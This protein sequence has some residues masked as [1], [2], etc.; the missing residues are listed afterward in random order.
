[1][2]HLDDKRLTESARKASKLYNAVAIK[3]KPEK[4]NL[5]VILSEENRPVHVFKKPREVLPEDQ[6]TE[7][8][9]KIIVRDYFP[10]LP[11]LKAQ[12]EYLDALES[13]D[14]EALRRI[15]MKF[16]ADT[17]NGP[18][19]TVRR[20]N[21]EERRFDVDTEMEVIA[22]E[23]GRNEEEDANKPGPSNVVDIEKHTVQSFVDNFVSEDTKSFHD[24]CKVDEEAHRKVHNWIY[25]AEEKHN[26]EFVRKAIPMAEEA[27]IQMIEARKPSDQ[28][29]RPNGLDNWSYKAK[30]TVLFNIEGAAPTAKEFVEQLKANQKVINKKATR[31]DVK[32]VG[33]KEPGSQQSAGKFVVPKVDISGQ[34]VEKSMSHGGFE[35]LPTPDPTPQPEDSPFITWG[36]IDGTPFRLDGGDMT[37]APD[38]A[39]SF[40]LPE[41][42]RREIIA[43]ELAD[44]I[45]KNNQAKREFSHQ[46]TQKL[47]NHHTRMST[48][49]RMAMMS[50]AA[51]KLAETKLGIKTKNTGLISKKTPGSIRLTPASAARSITPLITRK[52][53]KSDM[54]NIFTEDLL[55]VRS[56]A[57]A[58]ER[59]L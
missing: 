8:L 49:S 44:K 26:E 11:K 21:P 36:Q 28:K 15:Q 25:T 24:V 55:S 53:D 29:D 46:M 12:K 58:S 57:R 4:S 23:E 18:A 17:L 39:P 30:N 3:R 1:M 27:D 10:E 50:P 6:F 43:H 22:N 40:K 16:S 47:K 2:D 56:S 54:D 13:N 52:T 33:W 41:P 35:A 7:D 37:P 59:R 31:I 51:H 14:V 5:K 19:K 42:T 38:G 9:Q 32:S 34:I 48:L 20:Y 45:K